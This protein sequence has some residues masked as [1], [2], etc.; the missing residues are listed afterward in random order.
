[1]NLVANQEYFMVNVLIDNFNTTGG[2]GC[3]GCSQPVC[4]VLN[5]I[6]IMTTQSVFTTLTSPS[7]P[8]SNFA[9]W[10][11]GTGANCQS[12]P[13]KQ[14]TWGAVKALYR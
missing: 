9:T 4:I 11:G 10:Q 3:A 13:V 1:V 7:S 6:D 5:S 14:A 8:G 2:G 12:V